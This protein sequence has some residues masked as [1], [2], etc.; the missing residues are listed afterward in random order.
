M[1]YSEQARRIAGLDLDGGV[2][3]AFVVGVDLSTGG[4][5]G[6]Y[7][8]AEVAVGWAWTPPAAVPGAIEVFNRVDIQTTV[9]HTNGMGD[10]SNPDTEERL[11]RKEVDAFQA[12]ILRR[13]AVRSGLA[14]EDV[15]EG[16]PSADEVRRFSAH[17]S[18]GKT[19]AEV[20]G[21]QQHATSGGMEHAHPTDTRA[22]TPLIR[23]ST[24]DRHYSQRKR[25]AR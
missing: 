20:V 24:P 6:G 4:H 14:T 21:H 18:N 3:P 23:R 9:F 1:G 13:R 8:H 2:D 15:P 25:F 5:S 17:A 7:K 12:E 22:T 10:G 19:V 16:R 11:S